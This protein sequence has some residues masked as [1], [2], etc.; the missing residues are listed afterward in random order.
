MYSTRRLFLVLNTGKTEYH[1]A[2]QLPTKL[3]WDTLQKLHQLSQNGG[4]GLEEGVYEK[5]YGL[6]GRGLGSVLQKSCTRQSTS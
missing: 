1:G 4:C 2:S 6:M 3:A 5:E